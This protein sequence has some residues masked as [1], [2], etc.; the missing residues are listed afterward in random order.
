MRERKK[1]RG[2]R[3]ALNGPADRLR[4]ERRRR[5]GELHDP[6]RRHAELQGTAHRQL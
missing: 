6:D 3:E 5:G 2:R 1:S 4:R